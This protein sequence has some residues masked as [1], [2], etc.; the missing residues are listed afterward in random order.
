MKESALEQ[1]K[2]DGVKRAVAFSQYPQ[3]SCTT[4]G[5]SFNRLWQAEE[6][7][8]LKGEFEWSVIDRWPTQ[9]SFIQAHVAKIKEG[10]SKVPEEHKEKTVLCF[11]AHSLPIKV[12]IFYL[13]IGTL[14]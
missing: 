7:L 6:E 2:K 12:P 11:S 8:G 4:A 13:V 1:M 9:P 10:L 3:W 14:S 5:S